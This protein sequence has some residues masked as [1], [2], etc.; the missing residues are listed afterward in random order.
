MY[1]TGSA[2]WGLRALFDAIMYD[3]YCWTKNASDGFYSAAVSQPQS[4]AEDEVSRQYT[5]CNETRVPSAWKKKTKNKL[6]KK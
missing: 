3:I 5:L 4:Q 6:M 1:V 2:L